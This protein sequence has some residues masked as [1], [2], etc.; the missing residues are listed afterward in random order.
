MSRLFKSCAVIVFLFAAV[1]A[2]AQVSQKKSE[3]KEIIIQ[4]NGSDNGNFSIEIN[5]DDIMVNGK[6]YKKSEGE[7]IIRRKV[8]INGKT[9]EDYNSEEEKTDSVAFLG[10][11]TE[12]DNK[13]V[14]INTISD[15]SAASETGL[16]EGDIITKINDKKIETPSDLSDAITSYQPKDEITITYIRNGKT[17]STKAVLKSKIVNRKVDN[18]S[19][20]SFNF[21]GLED[22]DGF[23][24]NLNQ[25]PKKEKLGIKIQ[26]TEEENGVKII[27]VADSSLAMDSGLKLND[28]LFEIEGQKIKNTDDARQ[29]LQQSEEKSSYT[30]KINRKGNEMTIEIKIPKKLK[31]VDL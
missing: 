4:K 23:N 8:I 12:T 9:V 3:S 22:L 6:P 21:P 28:I 19:G 5:G 18:D 26:D 1:N 11:I 30:L 27:G 24:L 20:L 16:K 13:G 14:K 15:K 31:T 29:L 25:F 10:V 17:K 2:T 7:P